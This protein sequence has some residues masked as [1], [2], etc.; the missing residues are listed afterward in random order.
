MAISSERF[1]ERDEVS[2]IEEPTAGD[3][4]QWLVVALLAS[5]AVALLALAFWPGATLIDRLR[6]LVGGICAQLPTHMFYPGGQ[7]LPLCA[8]NTGIYLGFSIGTIAL[9]ARGMGRTARMPKG[10]LALLL[11]GFV[12]VLG[13][14]GINSFLLDLHLPHLYQPNNLLRLTTGLLT[15]TTM[16]AFLLPTLNGVLWRNPDPRAAYRSPRFLLGLAPFLVLAFALVASQWGWLLY[17]LAILSSAGVVLALSLI[18]LT[19]TLAFTGRIARFAT[20][21]QALPI[22]ALAVALAI[23][24]LL[25]LFHFK[26]AMLPTTLR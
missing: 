20:Y 21:R 9:F 13:V 3:P 2:Y 7:G 23:I 15:G 1:I 10:W 16:A 26:Q 19:F 12:G 11:L 25:L 14:D 17:P 18:N 4:P 22:F 24:E 6:V 8:R 5:F